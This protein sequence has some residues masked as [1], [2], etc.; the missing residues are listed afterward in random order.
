MEKTAI[1]YD[2]AY[3]KVHSSQ[4]LDLYEP[5]VEEVSPDKKFPLLVYVHGGFWMD[6]DKS[7]YVEM[8][9]LF[10]SHGYMVA[11]V[12]Y[13]LS[14]QAHK[15]PIRYPVHNNDFAESLRWLVDN[16]DDY[17]YDVNNITLIGH[18]CGGHMIACLSMQPNQYAS[19]AE[20]QGQYKITRCIGIQGIYDMQQLN[21]DFP[22][23]KE[24]ISFVFN[25]D[26]VEQWES[27]QRFTP[28]DDNN[29]NSV[30]AIKWLLVHSPAD[31][32]VNSVQTKNFEQRLQS[33]WNSKVE[34]LD[35]FE[36]THFEVVIKLGDVE[37]KSLE[38]VRESILKFL[39]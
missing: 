11:V 10:A 39:L 3:G 22:D 6:R 16:R 14:K 23:Y 38:T 32:L 26:D 29:K 20:I 34:I 4:K 2:E 17:R 21:T 37:H 12:N 33:T 13:R 28:I 19:L 9:R 18:S 27:P 31:K 15:T 36:A 30:S 35:S 25:N 24:N 5:S 1:Y 7:D 8:G